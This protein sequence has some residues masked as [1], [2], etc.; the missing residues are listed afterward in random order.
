MRRVLLPAA[1]A[2]ALL[3]AGC[4]ER[5]NAA[6]LGIPVTMA[7]PAAEPAQGE[8]FVVNRSSVHAFWGLLALSRAD[9]EGALANQLLGGRGVSD[10]KITVR[11]KWTDVLFTVVTLG[12]LVP[13][14]VTFEGVITGAPT[15]P[16]PVPPQD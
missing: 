14:T 1:A 5:F 16:V 7:S 10:V 3:S 11:S 4:V 2:L 9:L 13:R 6:Q 15:P 8:R 12:I